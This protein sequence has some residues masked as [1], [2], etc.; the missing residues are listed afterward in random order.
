[1][2]GFEDRLLAALSGGERRWV[3]IAA[4]VCQAPTIVLLDDPEND[5]DLLLTHRGNR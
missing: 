1:M 4:L 3:Q 2:G 5:L